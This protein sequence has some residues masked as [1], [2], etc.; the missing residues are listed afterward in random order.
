M[1]SR[2]FPNFLKRIKENAVLF[3][4]I[5]FS[6]EKMEEKSYANEMEIK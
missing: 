3:I 6:M 2:P 1:E 4:D 5:P